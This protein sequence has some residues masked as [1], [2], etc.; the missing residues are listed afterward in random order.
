MTNPYTR[1]VNYL[2]ER[3]AKDKAE[4]EA[5]RDSKRAARYP[6]LLGALLGGTTVALYMKDKIDNQ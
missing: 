6:Y 2:N 1:T 5:H 3:D 4:Y